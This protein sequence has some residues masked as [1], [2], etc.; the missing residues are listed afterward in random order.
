MELSLT[1]SNTGTVY[2]LLEFVPIA[3]AEIYFENEFGAIKDNKV[4]LTGTDTVAPINEIAFFEL[5]TY[6]KSHATLINMAML[7]ILFVGANF[8][9]PL[10]WSEFALIGLALFAVF[11]IFYAPKKYYVQ[12]VLGQAEKFR[13]SVKRRQVQDVKTL[14]EEYK[15]Y[16]FQLSKKQ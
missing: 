2:N 6:K 5:Y 14:I 9:L 7:A 10:P 3:P 8:L 16:C 15:R 11:L 1:K 4:Y 12:I 13:H